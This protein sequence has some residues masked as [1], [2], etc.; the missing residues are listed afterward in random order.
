MGQVHLTMIGD[1]SEDGGQK[2]NP[3]FCIKFT[4][5]LAKAGEEKKSS[6][7]HF[8]DCLACNLAAPSFQPTE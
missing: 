2:L 3:T 7:A 1:E 5:C 6:M 8:H 4:I